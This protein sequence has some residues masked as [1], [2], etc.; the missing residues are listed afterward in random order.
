[1]GN[2]LVMLHQPHFF[3]EFDDQLI[4]FISLLLDIC[5]VVWLLPLILDFLVGASLLPYP[6]V[7]FQVMYAAAVRISQ[8][9]HV[10]GGLTVQVT[11]EE[12]L[13]R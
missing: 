6:G 12:F 4:D 1:M 10:V 3:I 8:F 7:V 5:P 11:G 13:A 9:E 2:C